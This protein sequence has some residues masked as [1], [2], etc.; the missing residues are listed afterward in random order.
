MF[1]VLLML[2]LSGTARLAIFK[3][4]CVSVPGC[5]LCLGVDYLKASCSIML[6]GAAGTYLKSLRAGF[7]TYFELIKV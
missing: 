3:R 6:S 2:G 4:V 7:Y 5:V 1:F